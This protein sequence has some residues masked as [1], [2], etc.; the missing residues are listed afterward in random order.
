MNLHGS[1]EPTVLLRPILHRVGI[2]WQSLLVSATQSRSR[3]PGL[4]QLHGGQ[5]VGALR[6]ERQRCNFVD[7]AASIAAH[8][9]AALSL[10]FGGCSG[11]PPGG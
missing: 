6:L 9:P 5:D 4:K 11:P 10:L 1:D 7:Q 8:Q 2:V 3:L